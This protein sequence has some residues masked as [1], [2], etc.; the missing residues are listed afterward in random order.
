[1]KI[2]IVEDNDILRENIKTYL[3]IKWFKTET[4]STYEW[5]ILKVVEFNPDVIILD[6]WLWSSNWDWI[7]ICKNLRSK[8]NSVPILILTARTLT[9]QKILWLDSWADDYLTKPFDYLELIA[10]IEALNRRDQKLKWNIINISDIKIDINKNT[11][12]KKWE[13]IH[14]SKLEFSLITY[15]SKN[16]W[17]VIKKEELLEKVW[18]EYYDFEQ[19]RTVD[20]YIWYL[21]KKLGADLIKTIRWVWYMLP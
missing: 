2:L 18:W 9:K 16:K 8:W 1:M 14:L 20:I 19:S 13:L 5:T 6:L 17:R 7:D 3:D 10:R 15:L 12:E 11:L 21:R 4:H